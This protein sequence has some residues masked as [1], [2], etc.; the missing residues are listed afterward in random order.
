MI[1][2]V[3]GEAGCS[4]CGRGWSKFWGG[5][6]GPASGLPPAIGCWG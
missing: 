1:Y 6:G 2:G 3:G 4:Q 5:A